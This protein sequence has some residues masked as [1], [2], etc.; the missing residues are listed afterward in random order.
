MSEP[1]PAAPAAEPV[2]PTTP[3][4]EPA[5]AA[6]PEQPA[7]P[8]ETT[9]TEGANSYFTNEQLNEMQRFF[10]NNGGY[11][12]VWKKMK[13]SIS[14][15]QQQQ[16]PQATQKPQ[17]AL[18]QVQM[19]QL[20]QQPQQVPQNVPEG[21]YSMEEMAA[22]TY[23]DRL[24]NMEKYKNISDDIRSGKVLEGLK[25]FNIS[26]IK[27]GRVNDADV[28][29]YLDL[30][31]QTKPATPTSTTPSVETQIDYIPVDKVTSMEE[32]TKIQLQNIKL[33]AEGKPLHPQTQAASDF[34]KA[35]YK[36]NK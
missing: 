34:V 25:S 15:P 14:N 6:T 22:L 26:P 12:S 24:A 13:G 9:P 21:T 3:A 31:A 5:P 32:A 8:V 35:Y 2:A 27:D 4:P 11:D 33:R 16:Q 17:E 20:P 28:R 18:Q 1:V 10:A 29:K 19:G 23:F 36:N 7:Q 30:Y